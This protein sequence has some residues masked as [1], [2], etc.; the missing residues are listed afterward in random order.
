MHDKN[1]SWEIAVHF[2]TKTWIFDDVQTKL[3]YAAK[4]WGWTHM[5]KVHEK[6]FVVQVIST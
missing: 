1:N 5:N 2:W 6:V 3:K 4:T